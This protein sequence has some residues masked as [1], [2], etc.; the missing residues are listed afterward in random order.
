[1]NWNEGL[2]E[3]QSVAASHSGSHARLL[4]GPGTGKTHV[5]TRRIVYLVAEKS[6]APDAVVALTFTRAAAREL[7]DRVER[8]LGKASTPRIATLHA[9]ALRQLLR[10]SRRLD[11]LPQPLRIADDWEERH[12]ILEN[13]KVTLSHRRIDDTKELLARLAADWESLAAED[14]AWAPDPAF[15]GAW[16]QQRSVLGYTL[17]SEL[18]YQLKR[19]LEQFPSFEIEGPITHLLVDEYQDLNKCDLAV[20]RGVAREGVEVFVAGDDDQS[21]YGFRKAHPTGIRV[22][23]QTYSGAVDL[24]LKVCMRC[25]EEILS[26]ADFVARLDPA[27]IPK[28]LRAETGRSGGTV[29]LLV[30]SDQVA[31]AQGIARLCRRL[32]EAELDPQDILILLRADRNHVF[33]KPLMEALAQEQV[34]V[35]RGGTEDSYLNEP[36]GRA[37]LAFL[38]LVADPNDDLAWCT[39]LLVRPNHIGDKARAALYAFACGGPHRLSEAL[40]LVEAAPDAIAR[41]GTPIAEERRALMGVVQREGPALLNAPLSDASLSSALAGASEAM[42]G[43][44]ALASDSITELVRVRRDAGAT[45]VGELLVAVEALDDRIEQD[46]APDKVNILTMHKAKGLTAKAVFVVGAEDEQLPGDADQEPELGDE[47][48]LLYVLSHAQSTDCLSPIV[49]SVRVRRGIPARTLGSLDG[50]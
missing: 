9:F 28:D 24:P 4:A 32:T 33:S 5:L 45:A 20:I 19:A 1:M 3:E 7:R 25:D 27:R 47:R 15:L 26:L 36:P 43:D 40:R 34:P 49:R 48:R 35:S 42:L 46:V 39:L 13:L 37:L 41:F 16:R 11:A 29:N 38:R 50:R 10:N 31:E 18:T 44:A 2:S 17:R 8:V 21:I 22:F 14:P 30:F 23:P 6:V 12:V